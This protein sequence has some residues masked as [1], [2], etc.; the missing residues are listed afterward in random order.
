[1]RRLTPA[2]AVTV[3]VAGLWAAGP[4]VTTAAAPKP[5]FGAWKGKTSEGGAITFR[6]AKGSK[7]YG[8]AS[9]RSLKFR[10]RL[11]CGSEKTYTNYAGVYPRTTELRDG[12][13]QVSISLTYKQ[14][15][16]SGKQREY[17][18]YFNGTFT[19]SA[20]VKGRMYVTSSDTGKQCGTRNTASLGSPLDWKAAR[21]GS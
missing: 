20:K 5:A 16:A 19:S 6:I 17:Y 2:V 14:K 1:M 21:T 12:S 4:A 8:R 18:L 9:L 11:Y 10:V 15:D 13:A 3:A 7:G